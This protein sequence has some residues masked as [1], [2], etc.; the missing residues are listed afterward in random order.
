MGLMNVF[1]KVG[2]NLADKIN[3]VHSTQGKQVEYYIPR[4]PNSVY[5]RPIETKE[6]IALFNECKNKTFSDL[7][8][9]NMKMVKT[10]IN[11]IGKPLTYICN[12]SFTTGSFPQKNENRESY[13]TV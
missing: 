7:N 1:V 9:I 10:V 5:L 13:S 8:E 3:D 12:L 6:I 11:G 4:T 2:P